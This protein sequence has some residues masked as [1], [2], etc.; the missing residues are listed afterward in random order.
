MNKLGQS[1]LSWEGRQVDLR[2]KLSWKHPTHQNCGLKIIDPPT[3]WIDYI[4][5]LRAD[6]F[7]KAS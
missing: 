3:V 6:L 5:K 2:V 7:Q 4:N 1:E